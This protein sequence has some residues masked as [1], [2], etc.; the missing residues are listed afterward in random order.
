MK[1]NKYT[2]QKQS[3][4]EIFGGKKNTQADSKKYR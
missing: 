3:H 4:C 2:K 1:N